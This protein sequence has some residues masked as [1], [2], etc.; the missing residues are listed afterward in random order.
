MI[1]TQLNKNA[2]ILIGGVG[3]SGTRVVAEIV[4][5]ANIF[6]GNELNNSLDN[7]TLAAKFPILRDSIQNHNALAK[8]IEI[9]ALIATFADDILTQITAEHHYCAWG[10]KIPANFI[11]LAYFITAYPQMKYI[12]VIRHGLDMAFS[13]NRNQLYNWGEYFGVDLQQH[14]IKAAL[15]YWLKAN[16]FAISQGS[17]LLGDN[18]LLVNFDTLC[19]QPLATV[20]QLLQFLQVD[21]RDLSTITQF[22]IIP[23]TTHRYLKEDIRLFNEHEL[24]SVRE[25]GFAIKI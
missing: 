6:I 19:Q 9:S 13:S 23:D 17:A 10:W 18:F 5:K 4:Q 1:T 8:E 15:D 11:A 21:N 22:I 14:P 20:Q 25:L 2:P 3:G 24:N 12:H 16:Q 7:M